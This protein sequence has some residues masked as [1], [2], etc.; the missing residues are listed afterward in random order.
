MCDADG[1]IDVTTEVDDVDMYSVYLYD[2]S[3]NMREYVQRSLMMVAGISEAQAM[4]VMMNANWGG[5]GL[6]GSWEKVLAQH[7][8]DGMKGAGLT[9]SIVGP[10][11]D[12]ADDD[13]DD[14]PTPH[15]FFR[16]IF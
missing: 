16:S 3:F 10:D 5:R 14:E 4:D 2:D 11:S 12:A 9:A 8:Y 1:A 7:V 13:D 6:V 15:P